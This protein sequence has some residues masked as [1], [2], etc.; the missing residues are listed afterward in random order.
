MIPAAPAAAVRFN[1]PPTWQAPAGFDPRRGHL[2]DPAWPAA[3][4]GWEFWVTDPGAPVGLNGAPTT[5]LPRGR[6]EAGERRRLVLT[7]GGLAV[8]VVVLVWAGVVGGKDDEVA[9]G[10]GSCWTGGAWAEPVS[11]DAADA[12]Y[13]VESKVSTPQLC[14]VSSPGYLEDGDDVLCLR[15]LD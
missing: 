12:A 2:S 15:P 7:L 1:P 6:L 13:V 10:V 8:L 3:T 5:T 14:P 11:C 9:T 4:E